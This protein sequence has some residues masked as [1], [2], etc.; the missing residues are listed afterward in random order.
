MLRVSPTLG[1]SSMSCKSCEEK[2][3]LPRNERGTVYIRCEDCDRPLNL[4][5]EEKPEKKQRTGKQNAAMH[6]YFKEL[7]TILNDSG[8]DMKKVLKP[9]VDIPWT[10][11]SVKEHLWKP[12][13]EA[14]LHKESTTELETHEVD[15][16]YDI[17]NRHLGEK[18]GVFC[19]FPSIEKRYDE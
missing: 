17:L 8:L 16:V 7:A 3:M 18:F 13:Q 4:I 6:V 14:A 2:K 15:K 19:D 12:I 1:K 11:E 5:N 9:S 10:E